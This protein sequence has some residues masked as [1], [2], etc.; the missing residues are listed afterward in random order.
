MAIKRATIKEY[1][2]LFE[3]VDINKL[4]QKEVI[5]TKRLYDYIIESAQI[6]KEEN[7]PLD[8]VIDEGI[9]TG[10]IGA[11]AGATIGKTI[12]TSLC[13]I[14]GI[15]EKGILGDLLTSKMVLGAIG[16]KL[17]LRM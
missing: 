9:L 15:Q 8:D 2:Q 12:M 6:A 16:A 1:N 7:K 17:G 14:L 13:N 5:N 3:G 11:V 4:T 10:I